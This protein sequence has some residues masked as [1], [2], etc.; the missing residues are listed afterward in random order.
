MAITWGSGSGA[1]NPHYVGI[2]YAINS[3]HTT[4]TV[5]YY[6]KATYP[7]SD[8]Q[9]LVRTG[10]ITGSTSYFKDGPAQV[11]V[12]TQSRAVTPGSSYTVGANVTGIYNGGTPSHS[13]TI[14]VPAKPPGAPPSTVGS[15]SGGR[16][17]LTWG[18]PS[19]N[20]TAVTGF[21][22]AI[23]DNS[24]FSGQ[25]TSTQPTASTR[26]FV[27][28]SSFTV[29][30]RTYYMRVRANSAAG[31]GPW[32]TVRNVTIPAQPPDAPPSTAA[33]LNSN[34]QGVLTWGTA[35]TNGTAVTAYQVQISTTSNFASETSYSVG[36][37]VR[38]YT[39]TAQTNPGT[40]YYVRVRANSSAGYGPFGTVRSFTVPFA[41]AVWVKVS[42]TWRT[43]STIYTKVS[44]V[45]REVTVAY[46]KQG[47][48]WRN[49]G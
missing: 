6:V 1:S 42:G 20:G 29:P 8:T 35:G 15:I 2:D 17:R 33:S 38:S 28:G 13:R 43:V 31:Y 40:T 45:W 9:T 26:S 19:T 21:Q 41:H 30:G 44:G 47:G 25:A 46:L 39:F 4:L 34:G 37:G 14:N 7:V 24:S 12:T 23:A 3:A 22:V 11:L 5:Y 10:A 32:G 49:S 36:S 48:T 18:T 27:F 16:P